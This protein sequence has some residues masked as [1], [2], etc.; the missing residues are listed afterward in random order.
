MAQSAETVKRTSMELG[1]NAP[2]IVFGGSG[3]LERS[4]APPLHGGDRIH[5]IHHTEFHP[6]AVALPPSGRVW[7]EV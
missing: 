1:G 7:K 4:F 5:H 2:F 3:S 6:N